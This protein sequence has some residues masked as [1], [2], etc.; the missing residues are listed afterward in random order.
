MSKF[1]KIIYVLLLGALVL[2][3]HFIAG[4]IF[5]V[6]KAYAQSITTIVI[7]IMFYWVYELNRRDLVR[8]ERELEISNND[9]RDAWK[10]IGRANRRLPLLNQI[11]TKILCL[12]KKTKKHRKKVLEDL[13]DTAV[14]EV[15][16]SG[17]GMF[18]FIHLDK[19]RTIAEV[20]KTKN[21]REQDLGVSNKELIDKL[22][23]EQV[24]QTDN[25]LTV[26][27]SSENDN[28]VNCFLVLSNSEY[29]IDD[30]IAE[31]QAITDQAL[32]LYGFLNNKVRSNPNRNYSRIAS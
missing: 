20:K 28:G 11:T 4:H 3:P 31:V 23:E 22:R 17:Y 32:I 6:P 1:S 14:T 8:K 5:S 7:L 29:K 13:L 9:L 18:R 10:Y 2:Q 25:G 21:I 26:V 27:A 19:G 30:S 24:F 16:N 15:M 12:P